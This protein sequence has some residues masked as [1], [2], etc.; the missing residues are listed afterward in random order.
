[1]LFKEAWAA[2]PTSGAGV[3]F[4]LYRAGPLP[5]RSVASVIDPNIDLPQPLDGIAKRFLDRIMSATSTSC[6]MAVAK[7]A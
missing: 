6:F 4:L 5:L 7:P 1:M 3:K 2:A